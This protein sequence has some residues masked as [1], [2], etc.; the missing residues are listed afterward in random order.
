MYGMI[1]YFITSY[2]H[3]QQYKAIHY[4]ETRGYPLLC[5][6]LW[7]KQGVVDT[8]TLR[9]FSAMNMCCNC[10]KDLSKT[11]CYGANEEKYLQSKFGLE[12]AMMSYTNK[13][14]AWT[15]RSDTTNLEQVGSTR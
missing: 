9:F 14:T 1:T 4:R 8:L 5:F 11:K 12:T 3:I 2:L 10:C 7:Y 6:L 13:N 15:S